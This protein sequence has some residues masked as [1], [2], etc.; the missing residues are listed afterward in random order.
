[1]SKR[2]R[3][4]I[5]CILVVLAF[6]AGVASYVHAYGN[7]AETANADSGSGY[8]VD[9]D[10][11]ISVPVGG[12]DLAAR[13]SRGTED[14]PF[15]VLEIVPYEGIATFG[16][17]IEGC[18]P[19]D[20]QKA[21]WKGESLPGE[22]FLYTTTTTT[23]RFWTTETIPDYV[24]KTQIEGDKTQY[25]VMKYVGDGTGD[26]NQVN[27]VYSYEDAPAGYTGTK[28]RDNGDGTYTEDASGTKLRHTKSASYVEAA[29]GNYLWQPLSADECAGLTYEQGQA[30]KTAYHDPGADGTFKMYFEGKSW[31]IIYNVKTLTHKNIFLKESVGLAYDIVDGV[32]VAVPEEEVAERIANYHAVVYTVT[33]EDLNM[34]LDLIDRADLISISSMDTTSAAEAKYDLYKR[35]DLFGRL[36]SGRVLNVKG[37]TFNT[38]PLDWAAAVRIY[39]RAT[40]SQ[41]AC[42]I[43]WDT[44]TYGIISEDNMKNVTLDY[45]LATGA[46]AHM[47]SVSGTQNNLYKLFL[48]LYQMPSNVFELYHGDPADF[49]VAAMNT[50]IKKKDGTALQTGALPGK[51]STADANS[52]WNRFTLYPWHLFPSNNSADYMSILDSMGIMNHGGGA[53]YAFASGGAQNLVW[54]SIFI[55]DTGTWLTTGFTS[56]SLVKNDQYGKEVYDYFASIGMSKT[57]VTSAE[58]LYYLLNGINGVT[59]PPSLDGDFKVLE[60]QPTNSF[61]VDDYWQCFFEANFDAAGT[62]ETVRMTTSE[63]IGKNVECIADYDLIYIGTEKS[64]DDPTMKF[65]GESATNLKY[66][67]AHTGPTLSIDSKYTVLCGWL[68]D[69]VDDDTIAATIAA[70]NTL[71]YSGNDLTVQAK[72]K[73]KEFAESGSVLLFGEG[74]FTNVNA[75]SAANTIDR[76]SNMYKLSK[77]VS[78]KLFYE[79]AVYDIT[80]SKATVSSMRTA[81][82][83]SR[84]VEMEILES[85]LLY[86]ESKS[87]TQKYINGNNNSDRTLRFRFKLNAPAG[88]EYKVDLYVDVNGDGKF[89]TEENVGADVRIAGGGSVSRVKDGNTY[90]ATR[91]VED[92]IGSVSWKLDIVKDGVVYDSLSGVSAIQAAADGS[93]DIELCILQILPETSTNTVYLPQTGEVVGGTV[94]G[95]PSSAAA[96]TKRF[97]ELTQDINGMD[98]TFVRK[99]QTEVNTELTADPNYLKS[100]YDM[101][102]LGFADLYDGITLPGVRDGITD[103]INSGRAVLFTHDTSSLIGK[104]GAGGLSAANL[105]W[106]RVFTRAYRDMFGMDRYDVLIN[107][108]ATGVTRADYPYENSTT[109]NGKLLTKDGYVLAQ[110]FANAV[111]QRFKNHGDGNLEAVKAS[112]VNTGAV[113]EY[114]YKIGTEI[115]LATTH[116]QYY[117]LDLERDDIVVWYC[118]SGTASSKNSIKTYY[119]MT[120]NDVRNNYYIYNISNVTYSGVGH[121]GNLT[122]D[123]IKLFINTF[124]AAY[125]AAAKPVEVVI[126]NDD[127]TQDSSDKYYL[128][129]DVDSSDSA[130]AFGEDIVESYWTQ[131]ADGSGFKLADS[132]TAQQSKRVYFRI[133]NNNVSENPVYTLKFYVDGTETPLAVFNADGD[134]FMD[135]KTS[136]T[137]FKASA[138]DIYYVDVPLK[139]ESDGLNASVGTTELSVKVKMTYGTEGFETPEDETVAVIMP[140]GLFP[141]D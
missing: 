114:P 98:I 64:L 5:S 6:G 133:K 111:L 131:V 28:Y 68:T 18:E 84:R 107:G 50:T 12:T 124:V 15:F 134:V 29:G 99:K 25:G 135:T 43:L 97:Y 32:R 128:C 48:M 115:S 2:A 123:E 17:H 55:N 33:P 95:V 70:Q 127:A 16:Y 27:P 34:N 112:Q 137:R 110:G 22:G 73:L 40:D 139:I 109:A 140:R 77:E 37:A 56:A 136:A 3:I 47:D 58:C 85:P 4:I 105:G 103:Y 71:A 87:D 8:F 60:L 46:T 79:K 93:E 106:G 117:Q 24:P 45:T 86:D 31:Y 121:N 83:K 82:N 91:A 19:I 44:K 92:R 90:T 126:T 65:S 129:V 69:S 101:L 66:L 14:N 23:R 20:M 138:V 35:Q 41:R 78:G 108:G 88:K 96:V 104:D 62:V 118:L 11:K 9:A 59:P 61:L 1:M 74:F 49:T 100:T 39:E 53:T 116:P 54:N 52:Y 125:R 7:R 10:G 67:Y 21:L 30:Y 36:D 75:T 94:T 38:N 81:L 89:T 72:E 132:A 80:K 42:P 26:Y 119:K 102:I 113:T 57:S 63:F 13:T 51:Y 130:K 76:N 120:P 141:L 122:D